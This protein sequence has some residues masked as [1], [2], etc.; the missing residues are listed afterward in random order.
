MNR[1]AGIFTSICLAALLLPA[2]SGPPGPPERSGGRPGGVHAPVPAGPPARK[3][4]AP[5]QAPPKPAPRA[6]KTAPMPPPS[7]LKPSKDP[8]SGQKP[9][10]GA[11]A[12]LSP[13]KLAEIRAR[14]E[15]N[16]AGQK[17]NVAKL[18]TDL[19]ALRSGSSVTP[20]QKKELANSLQ[21]LVQGSVK[22][23]PE[24]VQQLALDLSKTLSDQ[25]LSKA[26]Q[27]K[28]ASDIAAVL[29][30]A[31]VPVSEVEA[32]IEDAKVILEAS[33]VDRAEAQVIANDLRA[34]AKDMHSTAAAAKSAAAAAPA[35]A[36]LPK[37]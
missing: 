1:P 37:R 17:E 4:P 26:E 8:A 11:S 25:S 20:D 32:V 22:P 29:A 21:T 3:G 31:N 13:E 12:P 36:A 5:S 18:H 10:S 7:G 14:V 23:A 19:Q 16:A 35:P 2:V 30:S 6:G 9:P 34:I 15:K 28:L 33:G 27:M 24:L